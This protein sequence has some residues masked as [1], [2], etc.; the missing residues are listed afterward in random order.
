MRSPLVSVVLPVYNGE[1]YLAGALQSVFKQDYN[2]LEVIVV[3]DGSVDRS[4][5]IAKSFSEVRYLYQKN[6]GVAVARNRAIE[7]STGEYI[8]FLD[9]D[10]RWAPDKLPT[11]LT[12]LNEH[13]EIDFVLAMQHVYLEGETEKPSWLKSELLEEDHTGYHLG[14]ALMRRKA[15]NQVGMFDPKYCIGSDTDWFFRAKDA[16]VQLIILPTVLLYKRVHEKNE[17]AH[18][19]QNSQELLDVIRRSLKRKKGHQEET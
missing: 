2:P 13:S 14:T 4:A 9:Q 12:Y 18:A 19:V 10:D 16:G 7:A 15:F 17:S 1:H 5:E 11:Q 6:Q 8:A 3:D